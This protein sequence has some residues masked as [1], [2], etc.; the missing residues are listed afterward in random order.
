MRIALV[1]FCLLM[2]YSC[3]VSQPD[4]E[5]SKN[6]KAVEHF[7]KANELLNFQQF[8]Q[9]LEEIDKA[10]NKDDEFEMAYIVK[11]D[12]LKELKRYDES[13]KAYEKALA[14]NPK[15]DE[16]YLYMGEMQFRAMK[17]SESV[18]SL[19]T[20]LT[21]KSSPTKKQKAEDLL[22][23]ARFAAE[24]IKHPVP[25]DPKNLEGG[26]NTPGHEYFPGLTA[27]E[28]TFIFTRRLGTEPM[29]HED[30]LICKKQ[31]DGTWG[32]PY[33]LGA[34]VNTPGNEGT[35]TISTDGQFI[36]FACC[37]RT[38]RSTFQG[39]EKGVGRPDD[40]FP[41]CDLYF[42]KLDGDKWSIPRHLGPVI[43]SLAWE[44]QPCLS[45]DG[46]TLYFT[47]TRQGGLGGSDIWMTR[48][49]N[50]K[51]QEPV[52]MGPEINTPGN[53]QSPFIHPD[54]QTLYFSSTGW[55][56]F[57]NFD[58]FLSRRDDNGKWKK[59]VNLGYPVNSSGAE[60]G[61][62][63]SRSGE[64]AYFSTN[65][66]SDGKGGVDIFSFNLYPEARPQKL[67]YLKGVVS[68]AKTNEKLGARVELIDL[69]TGSRVI[70]SSSN[71]KS[72]EFL[73][74][75]Q[76]GKNYALNVNKETYLF[77]SEN[78]AMKD[79]SMEKPFTLEVKLNKP[80]LGESVVLRNIFFEVDSFE[81]KPE[82]RAELEKLVDFLKQSPTLKIEVS[83]HTDNTGVKQKNLK[84][85][86]NRARS[87][88][89]YLVEKGIDKTRLSYKGYGDSKPKASNDT[90]EGRRQNRRTEFTITGL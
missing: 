40:V 82:S 52:N 78:F 5:L 1:F 35:V 19:E 11:G 2:T 24:A 32:T 83:G 90:E 84:L 72:G 59:P 4:G 69:E 73:V 25:F 18:G 39:Q 74:V 31:A 41:G 9:A 48:F 64:I 46:L 65:E 79:A 42:S 45:S 81:L 51:F 43:N 71:V 63:V 27:D 53:E 16:V 89:N 38:K 57:G 23:H 26:I 7:M 14:L 67:S 15:L 76:A 85:S 30:F 13:Q 61:L 55:P 54:D 75:L 77:H 28:G 12:V 50:G 70:E 6:K 17:Y 47:S 21:T 49:E 87:V 60:K 86:E 3:A 88:Y 80:A 8:E 29:D 37:D 20:F 68:D 22:I 34:P 36:F 66:R 44:S 10:L 33:N 56:G 58:F 62:L